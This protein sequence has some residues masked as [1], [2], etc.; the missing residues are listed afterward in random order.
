MATTLEMAITPSIDVFGEVAR[1]LRHEIDLQALEEWLARRTRWFMTAPRDVGTEIAGLVE[2]NLAEI[3][4]GH[5]SEEDLRAAIVDFLAAH[6]TIALSA[7]EDST[8][9]TSL[10]TALDVTE[11]FD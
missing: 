1:Y 9:Q 8:D 5:A 4:L 2:L 11:R 7:L 3:S 10:T 6:P